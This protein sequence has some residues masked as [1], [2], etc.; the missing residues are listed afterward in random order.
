MKPFL[1]LQ[2]RPEDEAS[3][4][5][6]A[7]FLNAANLAPSQLER[8]RVEATPLPEIDLSNF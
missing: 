2:S 4:N 1:L 7:G 3:D 6:Y 8:I 5:E